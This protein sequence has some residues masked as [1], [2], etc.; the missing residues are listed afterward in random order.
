MPDF[1]TEVSLER[2][3]KGIDGESPRIPGKRFNPKIL[4]KI[5]DLSREGHALSEMARLARLAHF[6][7][8]RTLQ[9][10][11]AEDPQ[12]AEDLEGSYNDYVDDQARQIL[13]LVKGMTEVVDLEEVRKVARSMP[14]VAGLKGTAKVN[15]IDKQL[16]RELQAAAIQVGAIDKR[17]ERTL[18]AAGKRLSSWAGQGES[19]GGIFIM[20]AGLSGPVKTGN[21]PGSQDGQGAGA[22]AAMR[23]EDREKVLA[24]LRPEERAEA[25]KVLEDLRKRGITPSDA[26]DGG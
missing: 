3:A 4:R 19:E 11:R 23:Q 7:S 24:S 26:R 16:Q 1:E 15:A 18:I 13:P 5:L 12:F 10:W 21:P 8:L 9:R 17:A 6:P 20:D 2:R 25:L 22:L 14:K